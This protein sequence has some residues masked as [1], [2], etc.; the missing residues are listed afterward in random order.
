MKLRKNFD[1]IPA[2]SDAE[3]A[4]KKRFTQDL[5]PILCVKE[6]RVVIEKLMPG[7]VVVH[8]W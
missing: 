7:S 3:A 1:D 2:G 4:F 8:F 5:L 6:E